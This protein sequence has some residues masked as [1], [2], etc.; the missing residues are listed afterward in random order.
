M[1]KSKA[2]F[3]EEVGKAPSHIT[4]GVLQGIG[5]AL[6]A[7]IGFAVVV[8]IVSFVAAKLG[9]LPV[10]GEAFEALREATGEFG[11]TRESLPR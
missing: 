2:Q 6:G 7:T 9:W 1:A 5:W 3:R 4:R 10:I 8:G 11:K